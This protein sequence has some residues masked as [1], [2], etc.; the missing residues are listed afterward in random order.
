MIKEPLTK[1]DVNK[2]AEE[3][4]WRGDMYDLHTAFKVAAEWRINSVWH[5]ANEKPNYGSDV[6]ALDHDNVPVYGTFKDDD[7]Y[8]EYIYHCHSFNCEIFEYE[9]VTKW[10]YID[11]LLPKKFGN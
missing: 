2:A 8:G 11:D 4:A 1:E 5:D 6:I 7:N 10:A 3:Y 9:Y